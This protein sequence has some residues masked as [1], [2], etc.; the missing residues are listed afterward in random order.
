MS[1]GTRPSRLVLS[2][3]VAHSRAVPLVHFDAGMA[4][5]EPMPCPLVPAADKLSTFVAYT[6]GSAFVLLGKR[7][8][9]HFFCL[10]TICLVITS[11]TQVAYQRV[12]ATLLH[13]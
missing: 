6:P 12:P 7:H 2:L 3:R 13:C 10:Q 11:E 4:R 9:L 5:D 1:A 8:R